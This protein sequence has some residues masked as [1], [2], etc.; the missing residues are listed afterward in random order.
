MLVIITDV[1]QPGDWVYLLGSSALWEEFPQLVLTRAG[2]AT[3]P[4]FIV[5][6]PCRAANTELL[7]ATTWWAELVP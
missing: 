7:I 3:E 6:L 4:W 1:F 5:T 2:G